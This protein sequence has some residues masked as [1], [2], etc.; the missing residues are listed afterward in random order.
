MTHTPIRGALAYQGEVNRLLLECGVGD[1]AIAGPMLSRDGLSELNAA[2]ASGQTP[3]QFVAMIL[4]APD[5][6]GAMTRVRFLES[7]EREAKIAAEADRHEMKI[8]AESHPRLSTV[9]AKLKTLFGPDEQQVPNRPL[10]LMSRRMR[11]AADL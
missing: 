2:Y 9:R 5:L 8:V 6:L 3:E 7:Q 4:L 1:G 11:R 10:E